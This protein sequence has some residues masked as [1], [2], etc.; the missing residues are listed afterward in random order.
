MNK[1]INVTSNNQKGGSTVGEININSKKYKRRLWSYIVG[2]ATILAF[3]I[4]L[5]TY[6]N[7]I[8]TIWTK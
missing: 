6:F 4:A 7:I 2:I 8:P 3:V 5:L 1:I